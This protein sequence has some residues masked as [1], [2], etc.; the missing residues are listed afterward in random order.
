M[1]QVT[2]AD[3]SIKDKEDGIKTKKDSFANAKVTLGVSYKFNY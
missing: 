1:Y 2:G 3:L